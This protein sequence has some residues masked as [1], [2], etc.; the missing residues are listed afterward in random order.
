MHSFFQNKFV[1]FGLI[2][3]SGLAFVF[4]A[5]II[6]FIIQNSLTS[7]TGFSGGDTKFYGPTASMGAPSFSNS[8]SGRG[9]MMQDS[10]SMMEV[11]STYYYP[12]VPTPG[13]YTSGLESYETSSYKVF[14]R[15]KEFDALCGTL[16]TLKGDTKI[17]FKTL[18]SSTNNC[19]AT[20]FVAEEKVG[21]VLTTLTSYRGVEVTRDTESVTRHKAQLESQTSIVQQQLTSV[22]R[23]LTA[24]ETQFD[25]IAAFAKT[26]NSPETLAQ[27]IREK[28]TMIDTLTQ[29]K[30]SL[31]DQLNNLYQQAADLNERL[32]VVQFDVNITRAIPLVTDKYER[33]WDQAWENL[34]DEF[35]STLIGI[36][37]S[38]GVFLL[39]MLRLG[40]YLLI[41]IVV[42]RGFWK[43][44]NVVWMKW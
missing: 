36:T 11:D 16:T 41:L 2:G 42:L 22:Q 13:G 43:F 44:A 40:L 20:F 15:T 23:S 12:P 14:A 30:I 4:I 1:R 24:A 21:S 38:F 32:D 27:A 5:I 17:H 37:A 39:W 7:S 33:Q 35:T 6:L 9:A 3:I 18:T 10:V 8:L 28:L 26:S 25:E 34:Q 29:R 31:T 19:Y